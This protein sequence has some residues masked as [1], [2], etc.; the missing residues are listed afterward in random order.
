MAGGALDGGDGRRRGDAQQVARTERTLQLPAQVLAL[1]NCV[2]RAGA[3]QLL[4]D[5][6]AGGCGGP[7]FRVRRLDPRAEATI[8]FRARVADE[9]YRANSTGRPASAD[10][11]ASRRVMLRN[12]LAEETR[13]RS[14][15]VCS[16]A[17]DVR[18]GQGKR[19]AYHVDDRGL[20]KR[21]SWFAS[22]QHAH[23]PFEHVAAAGQHAGC[24]ESRRKRHH[25]GHRDDAV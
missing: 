21:T 14:T 1:M 23:R 20:F 8:D 25:A 17:L 2:P 3:V 22:E 16:A 19:F 13:S 9:T 5:F 15:G 4:D 10:R 24:V 11:S 12:F 7:E 6:K 18:I